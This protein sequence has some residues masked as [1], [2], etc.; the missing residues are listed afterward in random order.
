MNESRAGPPSDIEI[1][2]APW[3]TAHVM[4][5][6]IPSTPPDPPSSSTLPAIRSASG[7][8]PGSLPRAAIVPQQWVLCPWASRDPDREP[9]KSFWALTTRSG[10]LGAPV[11]S[12]AA[13]TPRPLV[14]AQASGAF[15]ATTPQSGPAARASAAIS[16]VGTSSPGGRTIR[17]GSACP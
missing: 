16:R 11:S 10:W 12:T 8:T 9:V 7:A 5:L 17:G 13:V 3:S 15:S 2:S 14:R 6:A 4:P 1:T